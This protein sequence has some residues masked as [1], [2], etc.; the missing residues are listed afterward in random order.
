[1][2]PQFTPSMSAYQNVGT[3][4]QIVRDLQKT[5]LLLCEEAVDCLKIAL[6]AS[7]TQIAGA[8]T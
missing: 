7:C 3:L 2:R 6:Q 1:M 8:S 4:H 5:V